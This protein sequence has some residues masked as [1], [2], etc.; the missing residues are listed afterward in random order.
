MGTKAEAA[1]TA[2]ARAGLYPAHMVYTMHVAIAMQ[3]RR[4]AQQLPSNTGAH[5]QEVLVTTN[6]STMFKLEQYKYM[7]V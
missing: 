3:Q 7:N 5:Q 2:A 6:G 4:H 1:A